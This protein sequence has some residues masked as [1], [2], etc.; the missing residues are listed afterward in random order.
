MNRDV[1]FGRI[2][3]IANVISERVFEKGK[4]SVS[5]KYF[6][7]Y[8][9]NPYATFTKIHTELMG[10][11]HKFGENELRLMDMFGEILSG[12]QPGDMEAKDLK[13]AFLQGF[14]SQQDALKNIM[15][16]DEAAE[17]WGYTPDH[18]K[19]L[20][21]EGKIKCVMIGKTWVVDRNQPSP[22]GAGNQV[23]YDNN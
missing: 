5:Q 2:L 1:A 10:Y 7:R 3:A 6:D 23:S 21:R 20:C 9:K 16:T 14:Y 22:R 19:R 15:G 11:A 13:P 4:P 8:K 17:L 18:I 12:I